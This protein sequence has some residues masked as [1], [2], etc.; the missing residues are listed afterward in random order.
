MCLKFGTEEWRALKGLAE[1]R[2]KIEGNSSVALFHLA[3]ALCQLG[4]AS[5]ARPLFR[6][7]ER[8]EEWGGIR[9]STAMVLLSD[10]DGEPLTFFGT[11]KPELSPGRGRLWISDLGDDVP[12]YPSAGDVESARTDGALGPFHVALNFRGPLLEKPSRLHA[13]R[14]MQRDAARR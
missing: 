9:R 13:Q 12:Y 11:P 8:D 2:R 1:T 4:D 7:L 10:S 3:W 5:A 6:I 14:Q